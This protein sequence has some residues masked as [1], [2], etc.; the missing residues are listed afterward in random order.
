[1]VEEGSWIYRWEAREKDRGGLKEERKDESL[2]FGLYF[3]HPCKGLG[4][5]QLPRRPKLH[6]RVAISISWERQIFWFEFVDLGSR[7]LEQG[8][9]LEALTYIFYNNYRAKVVGQSNSTEARKSKLQF[10]VGWC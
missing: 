4:F 2:V 9:L 10:E 7:C 8:R 5:L 6:V 3:S 1:M